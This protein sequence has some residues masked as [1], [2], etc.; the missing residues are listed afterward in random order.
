MTDYSKFAGH[1]GT[2]S[3]AID[4]KWGN[5]QYLTDIANAAI[6]KFPGMRITSGQQ[7]TKKLRIGC[8]R[9]SQR[10]SLMSSH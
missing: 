7:N 3:G 2:H 1:D 6:K 8:L 10:K 4:S 9:L 5:Y